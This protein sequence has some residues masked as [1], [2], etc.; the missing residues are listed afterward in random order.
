[1]L[2]ENMSEGMTVWDFLNA[3]FR[4]MDELLSTMLDL[5]RALYAQRIEEQ[6]AVKA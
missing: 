3:P 6:M 2:D 5:Y 1:M 4:E